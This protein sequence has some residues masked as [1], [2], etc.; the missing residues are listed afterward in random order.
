MNAAVPVS[1]TG[2]RTPATARSMFRA[3]AMPTEHGGRGLTLEPGL[4][5]VLVAPSLTGLCL[6]AA[7]LVAFVA[8]TPLEIVLVDRRRAR[9]LP[10]TQL[11]ARAAAVSSPRSQVRRVSVGSV[12]PEHAAG[13]TRPWRPSSVAE[14]IG[15]S[16]R[17]TPA[18]GCSRS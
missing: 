13:R 11:A 4:L 8:R 2:K 14:G 5:G 17:S 10:R 6:P 16:K 3:V 18:A 9:S 1:G 12:H 15:A 7:A